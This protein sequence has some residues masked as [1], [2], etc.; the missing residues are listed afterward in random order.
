MLAKSVS[1]VRCP[2]IKV[3]LT[4]KNVD[5]MQ[6]FKRLCFLYQGAGDPKALSCPALEFRVSKTPRTTSTLQLVPKGTE[7]F[8]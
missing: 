3:L 1:D 6:A 8:N 2:K 4:N 5:E 7:L